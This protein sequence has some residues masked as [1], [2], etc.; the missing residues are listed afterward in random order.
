MFPDP[1][2]IVHNQLEIT[3]LSVT[4]PFKG[5]SSPSQRVAGKVEMVGV[6]SQQT[7]IRFEKVTDSE[8]AQVW[9]T[10]VISAFVAPFVQIGPKDMFPVCSASVV[11]RSP[12]K[13][14]PT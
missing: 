4:V 5:K 7:I 12:I 13:S 10:M 9:E 2:T 1:E 3:P 8:A 11:P 6:P 14:L